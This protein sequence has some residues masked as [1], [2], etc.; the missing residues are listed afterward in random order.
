MTL[1]EK[2]QRQRRMER[3]EVKNARY[4]LR[5]GHY[6]QAI[7]ALSAAWGHCS[8]RWGIESSRDCDAKGKS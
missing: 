4:Y 1:R 5:E 8:H 6:D 2:I 7:R 3:E